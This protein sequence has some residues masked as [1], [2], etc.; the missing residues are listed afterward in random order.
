MQRAFS[1]P[2]QP[3]VA[4]GA[5][6]IRHFSGNFD[7]NCAGEAQPAEVNREIGVGRFI[8]NWRL[9]AALTEEIHSRGR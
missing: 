2:P 3:D 4:S 8:V 5:P 7:A 6:E 9:A 1:T